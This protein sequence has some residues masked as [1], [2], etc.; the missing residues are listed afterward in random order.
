MRVGPYN[1]PADYE[2]GDT[3]TAAAA[4]LFA[5]PTTPITLFTAPLPRA[6]QSKPPLE[7]PANTAYLALVRARLAARRG[8]V[9]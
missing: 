6:C 3:M 7:R 5:P 1:R 9:A 2:L 4:K 8:A